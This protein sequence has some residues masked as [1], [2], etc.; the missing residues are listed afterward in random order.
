M[1]DY[2]L[3]E[4][5][6]DLVQLGQLLLG[7]SREPL[8]HELHRIV[9]PLLL[10][11]LRSLQDSTSVDVAHQLV[12]RYIEIGAVMLSQSASWVGRERWTDFR[13]RRIGPSKASVME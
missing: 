7:Q 5:A 6:T 2:R 8:T 3:A 12:T 13:W 1:G 9:Q 10:L 4:S 11:L